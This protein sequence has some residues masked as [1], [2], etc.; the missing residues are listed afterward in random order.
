MGP[1]FSDRSLGKS[2]FVCH[3]TTS[4][5]W[6]I[7]PREDSVM[8]SFLLDAKRTLGSHLAATLSAKSA[9]H[10]VSL[11]ARVKFLW[12]PNFYIDDDASPEES[13]EE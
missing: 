3:P 2:Q 1:T 4:G 8:A 9:L 13:D 5:S 10:I 6:I 12:V 7:N 11:H